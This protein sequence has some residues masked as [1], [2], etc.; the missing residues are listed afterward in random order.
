MYAKPSASQSESGISRVGS[1]VIERMRNVEKDLSCEALWRL[2]RQDRLKV[3][4][5]IRFE[6]VRVFGRR[7]ATSVELNRQQTAG[8]GR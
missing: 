3:T 4:Y 1:F 2:W 8:E 5:V 6:V 7:R